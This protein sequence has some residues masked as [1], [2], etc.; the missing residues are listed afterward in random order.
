MDN[1]T[2]T[3]KCNKCGSEDCTIKGYGDGYITAGYFACCNQCDNAD[4]K[5]NDI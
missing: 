2:I 1:F 3:I 4:E 5:E